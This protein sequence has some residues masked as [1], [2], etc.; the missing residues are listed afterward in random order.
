MTS[1]TVVQRAIRSYLA[2][3]RPPS[4][5]QSKYWFLVGHDGELLPAKAIWSLVTGVKGA[6]FNT[7]HAV[8]GLAELGYSVVDVRDSST[9]IDFENQVERSLKSSSAQRKKR[10]A[11]AARIPKKTLAVVEQY[12]RN[13]DVVAEVLIRAK[14]NC[15]RCRA[16]APFKR[17]KDNSPYLEVHHRKQLSCGGE[18]TVENAIALCPNCHRFEH[19]GQTESSSPSVSAS[20]A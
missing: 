1:R 16:S 13:P 20:A 15:E 8:A 9:R 11:T 17:R 7:T 12:S 4:F 6:N 2:G 5:R 18:D 19:H 14:G 3:D 10:L